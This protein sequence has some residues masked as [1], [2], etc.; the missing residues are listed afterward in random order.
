VVGT[1]DRP[2]HIRAFIRSVGMNTCSEW[3]ILVGDASEKPIALFHPRV[4][5][6]R[7]NPPW[8]HIKGYNR[9]FRAARGDHVAWFN[10]DCDL[11]YGWDKQALRILQ[12]ENVGIANLLY[13]DPNEERT[14]V[15]RH[16]DIPYANFGVIS[17]SLGEEVG[18]FDERLFFCGGDT[19]ISFKAFERGLN[20]IPVSGLVVRHARWQDH[21]RR[22]HEEMS[23]RDAD[24]FEQ[25]W[26]TRRGKIEWAKEM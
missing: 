26:A 6:M 22:W 2:E 5:V 4:R 18:W 16:W 17:R 3:E 24:V 15:R 9:L 25:I 7:E 12:S 8:G 23:K 13:T 10:D 20:V 14:C 21:T 11:P 1:K 19:D